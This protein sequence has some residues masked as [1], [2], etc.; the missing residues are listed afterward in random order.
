M[1]TGDRNGWG[2]CLWRLGGFRDVCE[3]GGSLGK[4]FLGGSRFSSFTQTARDFGLP[5]ESSLARI[6]HTF[7][8][9]TL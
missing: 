3:K 4:K 2:E 5:V 7:R 1:D 8:T 6:L 9:E